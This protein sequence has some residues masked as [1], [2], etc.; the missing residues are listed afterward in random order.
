L[1]E[2]SAMRVTTVSLRN[3][4]RR[5]RHGLAALLLG[6]VL[7]VGAGCDDGGAVPGGSDGP[8]T[9]G[10]PDGG[11]PDGGAPDGT[12][13]TYSL[14]VT[15]GFG[16]GEYAAG[17]TVHVW[18][19]L[20][21]LRQYLDAWTGDAS[22]LE[23]PREWHTTLVMPAADVSLT[24]TVETLEVTLAENTFL[25]S[26]ALPKTTISHLPAGV[27]GLILFNHGTGGS[28]NFIEKPEARYLALLA[29]A[30]GFG[31]LG[32]EAEEVVAGD[33]DGNLKI[34]WDASLLDSNV[35]LANLDRLI[36]DL[37]A[38]GAIYAAT[39]LF[40]LGMSNGGAFSVS[41]GAVGGAPS[42]ATFPNLRF[43][44]AISFCAEGRVDAAN[45]TTTPTAWYMCQNDDN[46]EVNNGLAIQRYEWVLGRGI[47]A[48]YAEHP[49][50]PL[51]DQRF[52]RVAG[53]DA[54]TSLALANDLRAAGFLD[55]A[56][57]FTTPGENIV[58]AI[59]ATPADFPAFGG[60]TAAQ[61][62]EARAQIKVMEAEHSMY[63]DYAS[64][65]LDFIE[66]HMP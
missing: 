24:A 28:S 12:A 38:M 43:A 2:E 60:L 42:A 45:L 59:Q 5:G 13:P 52:T 58:A 46:P 65:A 49:A 35:D 4:R 37:R 63:S 57:F 22:L 17:T 3:K 62:L 20:D 66:L 40:V 6:A 48:E 61:G 32:T 54:A 25:G 33:L 34:R 10:G 18:A 7:A 53:V 27:R 15:G 39:P 56:S 55:A 30:R 41:L 44:A 47:D 23:G 21:P 31:V 64:R 50:S 11:A 14:T 8:V 26:T 19:D 9:D 16:S 51:Y 29:I 36:A 1:D